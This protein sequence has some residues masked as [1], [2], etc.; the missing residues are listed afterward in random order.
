MN[1]EAFFNEAVAALNGAQVFFG[2][3]AATAEE[4]A[5]W[6]LAHVLQQSPE[7]INKQPRQV[8]NAQQLNQ[9]RALLHE[10]IEQRVPMSYLTGRAWFAGLE[11]M[12]DE[13]ALVPRSPFAEL[14][15]NRFQP[16][17]GSSQPQRMLDL[18]TGGGCIAIAMA[19]TFPA[20][21]VDA[22]DLSAEALALAA[23]NRQKH[24]MLSRLGLIQSDL[25]KQLTGRYDLIASNPPY[26]SQDEYRQL[27][28]E[29]RHEPD[30]GLVSDGEGL[31][32]PLTIL[33][34]AADYLNPHG[35]LFLEV[36]HSDEALQAALP[37]VPITWL[38]FERGGTGVCVFSREELLNYRQQIE[39]ALHAV[40]N[41][42]QTP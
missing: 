14:I 6:L 16:W 13:R 32:I 29:Y 1:A 24:G 3:G 40:Q 12:A 10:R 27:P 18:C 15:Q 34:Q 37:T 5:L 38:F 23:E 31:R 20:A 41:R 33:Q 7:A 21:Q 39:Q 4:E 8:L 28:A 26:V 22:V 17:L 35:L 2:H 36:G 9:A 30:M 19:K 42:C 25:F 11:F